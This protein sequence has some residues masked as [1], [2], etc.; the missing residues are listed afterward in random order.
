MSIELRNLIIMWVAATGLATFFIWAIMFNAWYYPFLAILG[1][2]GLVFFILFPKMT[3]FV[4]LS[5]RILIDLFH[6]LPY[7][8]ANLNALAI[9]SGGATVICLLFFFQRFRNDLEYHPCIHL[10]LF[11]NI[12]IVINIFLSEAGTNTIDEAFRAFSPVLILMLAS[13][14]LTK[15]TD[16]RKMLLLIALTGIIPIVVSLYHWQTGQMNDAKAMLKGIPRLLGGYKNLRHH[17]L[18]MMILTGLGTYFLFSVRQIWRKIFWLLYIVSTITC[19][20]LTMIRSCLLVGVIAFSIFFWITNRKY[21][22]VAAMIG[23]LILL[24]FN[25]TLQER[26]K[27]LVLLFTLSSEM[28]IESLSKIGSGRYG[29]WTDSWNAYSERS[30]FRRLIGLGFGEHYELIRTSFL[31]FD[32]K[33]SRNL[34]THND[35]LRMLY[36]LGPFAL[37]AYIFMALRCVLLGWKINKYG[38][39]QTERD[40]GAMCACLMIGLLL[41]NALSNGTFSRTTIGWIFWVIGGITFGLAKGKHLQAQKENATLSHKSA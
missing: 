24:L 6:W 18:I 26:F 41:N 29:L 17:A 37:L 33:S 27:D 22:G 7:T 5:G 12:F 21:I 25:E 1:G 34:D 30:F 10:F 20:Y 38:S 40:L 8:I 31:E 39:T 9:Y 3:F 36:N 4:L 2:I 35:F 28:D 14:F 32:A 16:G 13:S 15:P 11:W 19:M 23:V